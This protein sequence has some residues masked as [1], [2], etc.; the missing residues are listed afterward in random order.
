MTQDLLELSRYPF[1][2]DAK[3]WVK[4]RGI[5]VDT[6]L[7]DGMAHVHNLAEKRVMDAVEGADIE[8]FD[9]DR[10]GDNEG[11]LLSYPVARLM[12]AMVGDPKLAKWFSHHEGAR[13]KQFMETESE[14]KIISLGE[15]FSIQAQENPPGWKE[16]GK[17]SRTLTKGVR[18]GGDR[19]R[20]ARRSY[21]VPF[22]AFLKGTRHITGPQ[23]DLANQRLVKG[24]VG[25]NRN[26]YIRLLQE[27]VREKVEEGLLSVVNITPPENFK[28]RIIRIRNRVNERKKSYQPTD[29]GEMS[30]SRLPPCM[31]QMMGM[32]QAGENMPHHGRFALV[33]FLN[34]IG[35][36]NE[37]IFKVFT[38]S[39]DFK[40]SIVRYQIEH[41]TGVSSSTEYSVPGCDTMKTGGVCYNPDSLCAKEWMTHPLT[42]YKVKG[43]KRKST[44]K[45]NT[46]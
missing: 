45:E 11:E 26:R 42:Y 41:I 22:P 31:R 13:A 21:W 39:P 18:P 2:D 17:N 33:T 8:I 16:K 34:A 3:E 7:S 46:S 6:M 24:Y 19:M 35:M 44:S 36:D 25:L 20:T 5:M 10:M 32:A 28:E 4:S 23:W 29:L 37:E 9:S 1:T 27:Y 12:V 30:I 40:E 38:S 15:F 43:K 14:E